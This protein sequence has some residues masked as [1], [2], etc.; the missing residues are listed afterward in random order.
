[1]MMSEVSNA[2]EALVCDDLLGRVDYYEAL[3]KRCDLIKREGEFRNYKLGLILDMLRTMNMPE[4]LEARL[5]IAILESW[6][7]DI[8]EKTL[9]QR[10]DELKAVLKSIQAVKG[11]IKSERSVPN[12]EKGKGL[13]ISVLFALP[14]MPSDLVPNDASRIL[15]LL[16]QAIDCYSIT[17]GCKR[18]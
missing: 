14:I 10:E 18:N 15:G 2:A 12:D 13:D 6:R 4:N 9:E 1:M 5:E 3:F 7:L 11:A 17:K 16:N 8:P